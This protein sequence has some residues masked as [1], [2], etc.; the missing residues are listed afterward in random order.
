MLAIFRSA[1]LI[2]FGSV[3]IALTFSLLLWAWQKEIPETKADQVTHS[4]NQREK[5][6]EQPK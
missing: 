4:S 5:G 1:I 6:I 3:W 2:I